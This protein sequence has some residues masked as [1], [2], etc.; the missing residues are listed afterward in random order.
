MLLKQQAYAGRLLL[1]AHRDVIDAGGGA[2]DHQHVLDDRAA[3]PIRPVRR[4]VAAVSGVALAILRKRI[5]NEQLLDGRR[6][7]L[8]GGL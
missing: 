4:A 5:G 8:E 2:R 1:Q 6:L 3:E 7:H